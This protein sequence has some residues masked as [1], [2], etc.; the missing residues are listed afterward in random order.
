MYHPTTRVLAV[1]ELLQ[2]RGPMTGAELAE[3]LEVHIR[4]LRR[5]ITILQD[6]GIPI[7]ADRGRHGAYG[8]DAGFKLPPMMFTN[9]EALALVIGLLAAKRLGLAESTHASESARAKLER[10]MPIELQTQFRALAESITL[11]LSSPS[12]IPS[13]QIML[14][15]SNAAQFRQRVHIHYESTQG[16]E[17]ERDFDPYGLGYYQDHW[18]TVGY[19]HLRKDLRSFRLDRIKHVDLTDAHFDCPQNFNAVEYV[20]QAMATLPRRFTFQVL[21]QTD[22]ITAQ[23]FVINALG[24]IEPHKDGVLLSGHTDDLDWLARQLTGFPFAVVIK[25][26][27]QLRTALRR[28]IEELARWVAA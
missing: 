8:L 10:V 14:T 15:L 1:L 12:T 24:V 11:D 2:T 20:T 6:L 5:Y 21:L 16:T 22:M 28:R 17:T 23:S 18:Y 9:D 26:P 7:V 25:K 13:N 4:T 19:C 3:R 27:K